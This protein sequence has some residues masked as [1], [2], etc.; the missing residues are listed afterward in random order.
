MS[1]KTSSRPFC[2]A[3]EMESAPAFESV[4]FD[5]GKDQTP[6]GDEVQGEAACF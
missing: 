3:K 1:Y 4:S 2:R 6:F 5:G